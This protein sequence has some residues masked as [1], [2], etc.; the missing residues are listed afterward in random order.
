MALLGKSPFLS[1]YPSRHTS[2]TH[3]PTQELHSMFS[4][5]PPHLTVEFHLDRTI[6]NYKYPR[7]KY[8]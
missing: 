8:F 1:P 5:D 4:T 7:S 6:I 3:L 2:L